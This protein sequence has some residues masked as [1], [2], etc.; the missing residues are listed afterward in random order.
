[1]RRRLRL[2]AAGCLLVAAASAAGAVWIPA[3]AALAQLLLERAFH[4]SL[5]GEARAV[6]WPWS[7][8][9]PVARLSAPR[10]DEELVVLSDA[11]GRSLAFAPGHLSG[12]ALPG[13]RGT[14][15]VAGH[16]DTHFAFLRRLRPDDPLRVQG[17]DGVLHRFRVRE[18]AVVHAA[19]ARVA[20]EAGVDRLVL[21]TC[22][23]FDAIRPGS[24]LRYAV[25][26]ERESEAPARNVRVAGSPTR[27]GD[28]APR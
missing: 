15:V 20:T 9:W 13:E 17:R 24:D 28:A 26:A 14:S 3:K 19:D 22:W 25:L 10:Q 4:R 21:V 23:P 27:P 16:R 6:P 11:S 7:D 2:L 8:A 18:T 5:A 1:V 12:T